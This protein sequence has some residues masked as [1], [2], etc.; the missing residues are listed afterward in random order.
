MYVNIVISTMAVAMIIA[1]IMNILRN[2][3]DL[4]NILT[5]LIVINN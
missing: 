1:Y 3:H 5:V 2:A 4:H